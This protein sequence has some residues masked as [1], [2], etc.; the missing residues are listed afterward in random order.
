[1]IK[2]SLRAAGIFIF[3]ATRERKRERKEVL[4]LL[5]RLFND[6]IIALL[7]NFYI[8]CLEVIFVAGKPKLSYFSIAKIFGGL[9]YIY[10]CCA[11]ISGLILL[12]CAL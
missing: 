10:S 7:L 5:H 8:L 3:S 9:K 12:N 11:E 6:C 4:D 2:L 1:M